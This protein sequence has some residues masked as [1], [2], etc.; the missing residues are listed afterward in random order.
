M[1][2]PQKLVNGQTDEIGVIYSGYDDERKTHEYK[3]DGES[4]FTKREHALQRNSNTY[5]ARLGDFNFKHV[6]ALC[7]HF[8]LSVYSK[9][10]LEEAIL[11]SAGVEIIKPVK[12]KANTKS[13]LK[14]HEKKIKEAL[15]SGSVTAENFQARLS[16]YVVKCGLSKAEHLALKQ[17][18]PITRTAVEDVVF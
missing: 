18:F 13:T 11:K 16:A 9:D 15:D 8:N 3:V 10:A 5:V 17:K 4:L 1:E 6:L 7:K 2:K 14:D 12:A